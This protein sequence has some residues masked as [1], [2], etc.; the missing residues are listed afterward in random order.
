MTDPRLQMAAEL[1]AAGLVEK[2][3]EILA[4]IVQEKPGVRPLR[5]LQSKMDEN[6]AK[7]RV[8]LGKPAKRRRAKNPKPTVQDRLVVM[9]ADAGVSG[10][11]AWKVSKGYW[12]RDQ[13][14]VMRWEC[15][16]RTWND[17]DAR[18]EG[19]HVGSWSSMSDCVR[20]GITAVDGEKH[21]S[22]YSTIS[23]E[24]NYPNRKKAIEP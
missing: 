7:L 23:V 20:Y 19:F 13:V 9:L 12:L 18:G 24:P 5:E 22:G 10:L 8:A 15:L 16:A 4:E 2:A 3:N 6:L 17:V 21:G 11:S 1:R 14:D